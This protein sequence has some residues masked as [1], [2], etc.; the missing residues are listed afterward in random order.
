M[1]S[2]GGFRGADRRRPRARPPSELVAELEAFVA[3]HPL[4]ERPR[5]QLMVALYRG[6]ARPRHCSS[7]RKRGA[8]SSRSSASSQA[9]RS[10][11][12]SRRFSGRIPRSMS[13]RRPRRRPDPLPRRAAPATRL[14]SGW[15]ASVFVG[16]ERELGALLSALE[17]AIS[18]RGRLV[19]IGGEP[20]I[21]KSRLVEELASTAIASRGALGALLGGGGR[22]SVLAVGAGS[23]LLRWRPQSGSATRGAWPGCRRDRRPRPRG[24]S[25]AAGS[26]RAFHGHR[27]STRPAFASSTRS[28]AS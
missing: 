2:F 19:V 4:R 17:G 6:A 22:A 3:R 21:G 15:P 23:S 13:S 8:C 20:G 12:S 16:R 24:A 1:S 27:S 5:G 10:S 25:A 9:G 7:T 14:E 28:R 26:G 18:G 11:S